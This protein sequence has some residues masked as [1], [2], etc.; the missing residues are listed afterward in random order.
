VVCS[1]VVQPVVPWDTL[2]GSHG[3]TRHQ[4]PRHWK[5]YFSGASTAR[6]TGSPMA[7]IPSIARLHRGNGWS[8]PARTF[9]T[10]TTYNQ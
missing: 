10:N 4:E 8:K 3:A 6:F 7:T 2:A 5:N 1:I 9:T